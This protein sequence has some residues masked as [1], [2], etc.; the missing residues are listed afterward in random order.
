[1]THDNTPLAYPQAPPSPSEIPPLDNA[2]SVNLRIHKSM[3]AHGSI[4][5]QYPSIPARAR[6]G[7]RA[8]SLP[9]PQRSRGVHNNHSKSED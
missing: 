9:T 8:T 7:P 1:M 6:R 2:S 4:L 5:V 3:D